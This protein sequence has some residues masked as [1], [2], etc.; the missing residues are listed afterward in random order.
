MCLWEGGMRDIVVT[1]PRER[2]ERWL[3]ESDLPGEPWSGR[4]HRLWIG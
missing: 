2:W 4:E 3:S 1:V